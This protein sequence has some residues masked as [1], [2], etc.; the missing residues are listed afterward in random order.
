[1][2]YMATRSPIGRSV[3]RGKEAPPEIGDRAAQRRPAVEGDQET[4]RRRV[5][6]YQGVPAYTSR[7]ARSTSV[8]QGAGWA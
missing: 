3:G 7:Q 5:G 1:M 8:E 6:K 2:G 4:G